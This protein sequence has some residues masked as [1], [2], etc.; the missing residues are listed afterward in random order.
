[1]DKKEITSVEEYIQRSQ[2]EVQSLLREIRAFILKI[3]PVVEETIS[4]QMPTYRYYGN[5]VHFAAHSHHIGF[6]PG[7]DGIEAFKER[8]SGL[9]YSK[10]AVQFDLDKPI[11]YDLIE[12]IVM[13]RLKEN[14]LIHIEKSQKKK[15]P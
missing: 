13:Y 3:A 12:E 4:Y 10:G 2:P 8:F 11:P 14:E 9:K 15:N 5:L 6:Y 7:P 1:M